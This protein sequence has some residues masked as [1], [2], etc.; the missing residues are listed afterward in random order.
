MRH[1]MPAIAGLAALL[2]IPAPAAPFAANAQTTTAEPRIV[3]QETEGAYMM[4]VRDEGNGTCMIAQFTGP[5]DNVSAMMLFKSSDGTSKAAFVTSLRPVGSGTR[6]PI[7]FALS[8][9]TS[10]FE[11]T[12][13]LSLTPHPRL[14]DHWMLSG[15]IT[16]DEA[17]ALM[18]SAR[19]TASSADGIRLFSLSAPSDL[20]ASAIREFDA[21][22]TNG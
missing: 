17:T 9:G 6:F 3:W 1:F 14:S 21:C 7:S 10:S 15:P 22:M 13:T 19:V 2:A 12:R 11:L 8:T 16:A 5:A 20:R 4:N 18:V